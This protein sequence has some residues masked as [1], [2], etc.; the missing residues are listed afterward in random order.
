MALPPKEIRYRKNALYPFVAITIIPIAIVSGAV[1]TTKPFWQLYLVYTFSSLIVFLI[2]RRLILMTRSNT[3]VLVFE[4][5]ALTINS[6]KSRTI[7]WSS[8][9][10]WKIRSCKGNDTLVIRT[11]S[12]KVTVQMT[13][14]ELPTK[15]IKWLLESY[16][17]ES[18][19]G[20]SSKV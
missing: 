17:R 6:R 10:Q 20:G 5:H 4:S 16:V 19:T 9:T 18:K 3:P 7:P 15:E 1:F 14:L 8:I 12:G 2:L 11:P 13:W